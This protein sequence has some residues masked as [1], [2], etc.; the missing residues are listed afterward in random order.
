M[1][2]QVSLF[3]EIFGAVIT[4]L[5]VEERTETVFGASGAAPGGGAPAAQ[6]FFLF[7]GGNHYDLL[8]W[9]PRPGAP[10]VVYCAAFYHP[11]AA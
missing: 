6:A 5:D 10:E 9:S 11:A 7:E 1:V 4:V 8:A 2:S 3:A